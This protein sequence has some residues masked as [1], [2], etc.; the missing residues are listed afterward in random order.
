MERA[1][2]MKSRDYVK[3]FI[4]SCKNCTIPNKLINKHGPRMALLIDKA[5]QLSDCFS[6]W[7]L[8]CTYLLYLT[9]ILSSN[10]LTCLVPV[11][12]IPEIF[13]VLTF[14]ISF[15]EDLDKK[16]TRQFCTSLLTKNKFTVLKC[17]YFFSHEKW[18]EVVGRE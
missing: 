7:M 10:R 6:K 18:K 15:K 11:N 2:P 16:Y 3:L 13:R 1:I 4:R 14:Y 17:C 5:T 9:V 8:C 12:C